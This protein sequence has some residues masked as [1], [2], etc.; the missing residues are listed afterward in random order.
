[1]L[2]QRFRKLRITAEAHVCLSKIP[3][4]FHAISKIKPSHRDVHRLGN[5][6]RLVCI[7]HKPYGVVACR[8]LICRKSRCGLLPCR[9][10]TCRPCRRVLA[11]WPVLHCIEV[12]Q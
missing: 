2:F 9:Q 4:E 12:S 11:R 7:D 5:A 8:W 1:M 3:I 10:P 6:S